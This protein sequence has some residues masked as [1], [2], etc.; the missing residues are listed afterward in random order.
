MGSR[1]GEYRESACQWKV[2]LDKCEFEALFEG[3][4]LQLQQ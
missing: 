3:T 4:M 1:Q 2:P